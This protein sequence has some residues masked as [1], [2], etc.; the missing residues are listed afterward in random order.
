[1]PNAVPLMGMRRIARYGGH[2]RIARYGGSCKQRCKEW[3]PWGFMGEINT[4]KGFM[5]EINNMKGFIL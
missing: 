2:S 4:M 3:A 5:G 1:M